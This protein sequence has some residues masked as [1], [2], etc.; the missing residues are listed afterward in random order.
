MTLK[1]LTN[2]PFLIFVI[3][4]ALETHMFWFCL[5]S[6]VGKQ[7]FLFP[8]GHNLI[9]STFKAFIFCTD[10]KSHSYMDLTETKQCLSFISASTP[11]S[12]QS[13]QKLSS[14][15]ELRAQSLWK[16]PKLKPQKY[17]VYY[18]IVKSSNSSHL[19]S[20]LESFTF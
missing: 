12:T 17:W 7:A 10:M 4:K 18:L 13:E 15:Y 5:R 14:W 8:P 3:T 20:C 2:L 1:T 16:A 9:W 11:S 19:R 6:H